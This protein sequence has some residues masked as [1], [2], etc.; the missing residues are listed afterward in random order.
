MDKRIKLLNTLD[1]RL[2]NLVNSQVRKHSKTTEDAE[3]PRLRAILLD[4]C[5]QSGIALDEAS[6]REA[7]AYSEFSARG[8]LNFHVYPLIN[9]AARPAKRDAGEAK[10]ARG[11]E[12]SIQ[13]Q[14]SR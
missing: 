12:Q 9:E 8:Q 13:A 10:E 1:E 4:G 11:Q 7:E 14:V 2:D 3:Y 5:V 6:F